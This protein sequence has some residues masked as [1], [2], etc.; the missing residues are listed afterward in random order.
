MNRKERNDRKAFGGGG[1]TLT[2]RLSKLNNRF[3]CLTSQIN[4]CGSFKNLKSLSSCDTKCHEINSK[5][6]S[7]EE[8]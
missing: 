6:F 5:T 3:G 2:L 7:A 1:E 4:P 8:S